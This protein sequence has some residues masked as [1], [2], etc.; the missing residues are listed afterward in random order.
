[1]PNLVENFQVFNVH[2]RQCILLFRNYL[3]LEKG[4]VL[5]LNK[6]E[7]FVLS[8]VEI[9]PV[10]LEQNFFNFVNL[11]SLFRNYLPLEK[12]VVPHLNKLESLSTKSE[13]CQV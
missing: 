5:Y 2:V 11:F 9:N 7:C 10:V 12:G 6:L 4:M 1:M 3:L 8:L 13:L